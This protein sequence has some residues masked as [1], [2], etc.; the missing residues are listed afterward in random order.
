LVS[1]ATS[2]LHIVLMYLSIPKTISFWFSSYYATKFLAISSV[3]SVTF[4]DSNLFEIYLHAYSMRGNLLCANSSLW[5][6][7]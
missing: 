5:D 3:F 7:Y 2:M 4:L 6:S 1:F